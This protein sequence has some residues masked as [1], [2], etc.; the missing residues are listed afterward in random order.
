MFRDVMSQFPTGV[1]V[2]TAIGPDGPGGIAIGSF[3]SVSLDPMLVGFCVGSTSSSWTGLRDVGSF[4]VNILGAD[5]LDLCAQ[6]A[7]KGD[8]YAGVD[9]SPA[10]GT[11]SPLLAGSLAYLDCDLH[12]IHDGGDHDIV[13]GQVRDLGVLD[14]SRDA[15]LFV[16]RQYGAFAP[17]PG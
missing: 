5:Q 3:F 8:K 10:A 12:A 9:W 15:L 1:T 16:R 4:C 17:L 7:G 14:D 2:V 13:I 6:M 11:G